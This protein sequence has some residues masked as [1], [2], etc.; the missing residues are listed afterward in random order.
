MVAIGPED[1]FYDGLHDVRGRIDEVHGTRGGQYGQDHVPEDHRGESFHLATCHSLAITWSPDATTLSSRQLR[2][3]VEPPVEDPKRGKQG[4]D[5]G[6]EADEEV[7]EGY[8]VAE[9]HS[10]TGPVVEN[11]QVLGDAILKA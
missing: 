8:P 9:V 3:S 11:R 2:S 6:G 4:Q 1:A 7:G 10:I 5:G